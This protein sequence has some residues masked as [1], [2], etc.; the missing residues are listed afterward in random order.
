MDRA[1]PRTFSEPS[2]RVYGR[3]PSALAIALAMSGIA[4]VLAPLR[5]HGSSVAWSAV[6][7]VVIAASVPLFRWAHRLGRL[8]V[9]VS[10]DGL[11]IHG[12]LHDRELA[13]SEIRAFTPGGAPSISPLRESIPVVV[14]ELVDGRRVV[15][16]ALRVDRGP[17][18]TEEAQ[19]HV[20]RLCDELERCRPRS[21]PAAPRSGLDREVEPKPA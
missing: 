14:A 12:P 21:Q 10:P 4:L 8:A 9:Q 13:W 19:A 18:G 20:R 7:V 11:K 16:D 1:K 6:G 17:F 2:G 3:F 15:L 5:W